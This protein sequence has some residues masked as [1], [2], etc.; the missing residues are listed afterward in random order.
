MVAPSSCR[1]AAQPSTRRRAT[2]G[3]S[4]TPGTRQQT[5]TVNTGTDCVD[6]EIPQAICS[7]LRYV[8]GTSDRSYDRRG[9]HGTCSAITR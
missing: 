1:A 5:I 6:L 9:G 2:A 8:Q 4:S 7:A 3:T